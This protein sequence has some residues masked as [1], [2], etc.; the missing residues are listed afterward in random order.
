MS[1]HQGHRERPRADQ[2]AYR[3]RYTRSSRKT[4]SPRR[5]P[6]ATGAVADSRRWV[7]I[8]MAT[9]G[10]VV[11]FGAVIT[12]IVEEDDG[13]TAAARTAIAFAAAMVPVTLLLL[14]KISERERPLRTVMLASPLVIAG[15]LGVGG[16]LREPAT[17]L[18]ASFGV[19]GAIT[20]SAL[21]HHRM[22][23]RLS[24]VGIA[25]AITLLLAFAVPSASVIAAPFLPFPALGIADRLALRR[26]SPAPVGEAE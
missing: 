24:L 16:L 12:A 10:L 22:Q 20:L 17:A 13:S 11:C 9:F 8:A 14:A 15:F 19:A 6:Q 5:A 4:S 25:T 21:P 3:A 2:R 26:P 1:R 7:A 18:V 23:L